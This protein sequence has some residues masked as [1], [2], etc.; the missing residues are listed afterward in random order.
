LLRN[1][2][3]S[4]GLNGAPRISPSGEVLFFQS[5][6]YDPV[7]PGNTPATADTAFFWGQPGNIL[8][9]AREGD[10]VPF[11]APGVTWGSM[12]ASLQT[13]ADQLHGHRCCSRRRCS[14]RPRPT[15]AC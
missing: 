7:N 11:L 3:N 13:H 4:A 14:A 15:T 2:L 5:A 8:L 12:A 10:Q 6:L 9:L 1:S